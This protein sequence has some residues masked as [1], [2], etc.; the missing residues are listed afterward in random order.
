MIAQ[1]N[2]EAGVLLHTVLPLRLD[3]AFFDEA[4]KDGMVVSRY[5]SLVD[6]QIRVEKSRPKSNPLAVFRLGSIQLDIQDPQ[7]RSMSRDLVTRSSGGG[8][9][10][11][12]ETMFQAGECIGVE[13]FASETFRIQHGHDLRWQ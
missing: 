3:D 13:R 6:E 10:K 5:V 12:G 11:V 4:D 9:L 2:T 1:A 8:L 7:A